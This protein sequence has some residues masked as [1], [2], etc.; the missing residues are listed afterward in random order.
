MYVVDPPEPLT[1]TP[2]IFNALLI[3]HHAPGVVQ[4]VPSK[5]AQAFATPLPLDFFHTPDW[6]GRINANPRRTLIPSGSDCHF[7][8]NKVLSRF[9]AKWI[10]HDDA[11][12]IDEFKVLVGCRDRL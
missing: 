11:P 4:V 6:Q 9:D 10:D 3:V 12:F 7:L 2:E 5:F 1:C 8:E